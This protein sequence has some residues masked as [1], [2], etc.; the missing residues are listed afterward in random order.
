MITKKKK[1]QGNGKGTQQTRQGACIDA[2]E[3]QKKLMQKMSLR[4]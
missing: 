1:K 2:G 4:E 3:K